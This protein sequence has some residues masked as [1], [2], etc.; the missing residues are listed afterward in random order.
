[1]DRIS[2]GGMAEI[3]RAKAKGAVG[4]E[5]ILAIKRI[6]PQMADDQEF[7]DMFIDEA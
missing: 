4:F 6:L 3:F 5:K 1:M 2:V 7:V